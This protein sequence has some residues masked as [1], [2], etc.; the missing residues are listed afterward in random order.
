MR[1]PV[2]KCERGLL[3]RLIGRAPPGRLGFAGPLALL[4]LGCAGCFA[5]SF[6]DTPASDASAEA[7]DSSAAEPDASLSVPDALLSVPD[8]HITPD[9]AATFPDCFDQEFALDQVDLWL[10]NGRDA[11]TAW[12]I[13][14]DLTVEIDGAWMYFHFDQP[15]SWV[16]DGYTCSE[17]YVIYREAGDW[18]AQIADYLGCDESQHNKYGFH[19]DWGPDNEWYPI[20]PGDPVV[21]LVTS[22]SAPPG[23]HVQ[24]FERTSVFAMCW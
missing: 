2:A 8:A 5:G 20:V 4:L 10:S 3:S 12:P 18:V 23:D 6:E 24:L 13:V 11:A 1:A 21:F 7:S 16:G 22:N 19:S 9:A 15:E 17:F 14:S